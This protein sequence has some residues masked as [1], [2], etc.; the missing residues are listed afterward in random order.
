MA[1]DTRSPDIPCPRCGASCVPRE[2][3]SVTR[4]ECPECEPDGPPSLLDYLRD[5]LRRGHT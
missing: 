5:V 2:N 4:Y 1:T 3:G